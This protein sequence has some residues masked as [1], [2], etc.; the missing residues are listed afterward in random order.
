MRGAIPRFDGRAEDDWHSL[1]AVGD[2]SASST[3]AVRADTA[4]NVHLV[5]G[6]DRNAAASGDT[7]FTLDEAYRPT[8]TVIR[9]VL[10]LPVSARGYLQ[11]AT[12]GAVTLHIADGAVTR[13]YLNSAAPYTAL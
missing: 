10:T 4:G 12:N 6:I 2:Y 9:L 11:V 13:Y 5:G 3:P 7:V 1:V 8:S